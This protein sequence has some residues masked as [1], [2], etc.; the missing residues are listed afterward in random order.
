MAK[1]IT[2]IL[3][4]NEIEYQ[5]A[6]GTLLGAVRHKG[7][8][9][10][11]DDFDL[12]IFDKDYENAISLLRA[13]LPANLF[14]EDDKSEPLYFHSWAHVKDLH[15]VCSCEFYPHDNFYA[16][17]GLSIDLYKLTKLKE[18]DFAD[19]KHKEAV[20]Y[21]DRRLKFNF[22]SE[23]DYLQRKK[24]YDENK[25]KET[26]LSQEIAFFTPF[27]NV[28]QKIE[29]IFPLKY[30]PFEDTQFLGPNKAEALLTLLYGNYSELPSIEKRV[31][32][33][34]DVQFLEVE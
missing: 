33:Y 15:S 21:I 3:E 27:E 10:W 25:I 20:A 18:C 23:E 32:H 29:D 12:F 17:H 34:S 1:T 9:P 22:I 5:L 2:S 13:Q 6:Y 26:S 4:K 11:D 24:V 30:Y 14:L 31:T 19:F 16:H 28:K 7:F 8:I